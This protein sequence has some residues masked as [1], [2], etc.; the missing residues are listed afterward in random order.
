MLH[1][2]LW[3]TLEV[4]W[5]YIPLLLHYFIENKIFDNENVHVFELKSCKSGY[6]IRQWNIL[7]YNAF[8]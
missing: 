4:E 7:I 3:V 1:T 2:N 6:S 8:R 5:N